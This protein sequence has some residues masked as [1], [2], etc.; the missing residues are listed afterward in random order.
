[1]THFTFGGERF[2]LLERFTFAEGRALEKVTGYSG[3]QIVTDPT[4]RGRFDVMQALLWVSIKRRRPEFKFA[5]LDDVAVEDIDWAA[6]EPEP[7][8]EPEN[9]TEGEPTPSSS[10]D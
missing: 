1:M 6:D 9:P 2:E 4:V 7:E 8:A 5:D 10:D 3:E